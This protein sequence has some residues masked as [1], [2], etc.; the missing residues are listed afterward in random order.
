M[1][2]RLTNDYKH[3]ALSPNSE[4]GRENVQ[5]EILKIHR[6]K[7]MIV[8][9]FGEKRKRSEEFRQSFLTTILHV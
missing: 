5:K 2:L 7:Q 6:V 4:K 3:A 9:I 1:S 8:L